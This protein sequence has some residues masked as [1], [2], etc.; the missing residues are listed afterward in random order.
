MLA[1][2]LL[3][4]LSL[5]SSTPVNCSSPFVPVSA[6][7]FVQ[8]LDPGWNLGNTLDAV[9]DEGS[10][11]NAKVTPDVFALIKKSGFR[12]VR[13]PVTY[14]D[15]FVSGS[16]EWQINATW[17]QR[18]AEVVSMATDAG[19]LVVTNMQHDSWRWA[20]VTQAGANQTEIDERFSASWRQ[21]GRALACAPSTVAFEPINE[22]P[23]TTAEHGKRINDLN[24]LF[25]DALATSGAH[26]PRRAVTL[27]GGG[28]DGAK[29]AEWFERPPANT[30]NPWAIQFHY[31]S[32]CKSSE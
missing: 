16:P 19:L 14:A 11:N 21:I 31:Y 10:W 2:T 25:L 24:R 30:T 5:A 15:H 1:W 26:N 18:V 9:P 27:V 6:A 13:I 7:D 3:S 23:A 20:D 8:R 28:E 29:T 32:P 22:P 4:S 12:S 17:L